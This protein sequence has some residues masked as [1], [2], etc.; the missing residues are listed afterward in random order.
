MDSK[1]NKNDQG[2]GLVEC[3]VA[4][5]ILALGMLGLAS[6][7]YSSLINNT[8][9]HE[10]SQAYLKAQELIERLKNEDFENS[11]LLSVDNGT[12]PNIAD[13]NSYPEND[14]P[15]LYGDFEWIVENFAYDSNGDG[16]QDTVSKFTKRITVS[17]KSNK[18]IGGG[19]GEAN[20]STIIRK[21]I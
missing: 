15:K 13:M 20:I 2:L 8:S 9:G 7:Q 12:H 4:I 5:T 6:M 19:I 10:R 18:R 21:K 3:L 14:Y 11:T 1:T 17:V 16:N